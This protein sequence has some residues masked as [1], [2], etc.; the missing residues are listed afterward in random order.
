[1]LE[2][3]GWP[4]RLRKKA[5]MED[6][7]ENRGFWQETSGEDSEEAKPDEVPQ[8]RKIAKMRRGSAR[9][10]KEEPEMN[11]DAKDQKKE[12]TNQ[13]TEVESGE[14]NPSGK[15]LQAWK[16]TERMATSQKATPMRCWP[17]LA[18]P[19]PAQNMLSQPPPESTRPVNLDLI[20]N[21]IQGTNYL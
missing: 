3:H 11:V 20:Q 15:G 18:Y 12:G 8:A 19:E 14:G 5:W 7:E 10:Q 2:D 21:P 16:I 4:K 9:T 6:L 17:L 1:M 13:R